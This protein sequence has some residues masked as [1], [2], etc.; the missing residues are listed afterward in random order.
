MGTTLHGIIEIWREQTDWSRATW[1]DI[2]TVEFN[3]NYALYDAFDKFRQ[4]KNRNWYSGYAGD[5]NRRKEPL[6]SAACHVIE[7]DISSGATWMTAVELAKI[8]SSHQPSFD[9]NF[10]WRLIARATFAFMR[11]VEKGGR[12]VRLLIYSIS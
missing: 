6:S 4:M 7:Q 3:K 12:R 9:V 8:L 2:A 1:D 5:G 11:E 10:D